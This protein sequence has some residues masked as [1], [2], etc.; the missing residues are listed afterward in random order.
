MI[1]ETYARPIRLTASGVAIARATSLLGFSVRPGA[2][3][4]VIKLHNGQSDGEEVLWEIEAD[5]GGGSHSEHFTL[6]IPFTKGI[7]VEF[8]TG[9]GDHVVNLLV[10]EPLSS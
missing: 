2:S 4:I 1:A 6:P 9:E 7:Y 10:L 3:D 8:T 5:N